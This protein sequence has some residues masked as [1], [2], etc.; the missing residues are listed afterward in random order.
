VRA[1][2]HTL[3]PIESHRALFYRDSSEYLEGIR[4][5]IDPALDR[6]EPVAIAVPEP[7]LRF[8]QAELGNRAAPVEFLDMSELGRNPGRIIPAVLGMLE[9]QARRPL[10]FV[11][12]PLWP[13]RSPEEI[14]E[15]TRHEALINLAWPDTDITV[16][17]PYDAGRL[18]DQV[19]L[20][21]ELTHPCVVRSGRLE[22]SSKYRD[23]AVPASCEQAL[24]DPPSGALAREFA[25]DDLAP[26]RAWVAELAD[27]S[28]LDAE[29]SAD[30]VIAINELTTNT[31]RHAGPHGMLRF[32]TASEE[33]IFQVE[34]T[35]HIADPLAG[36]R[37]QLT[38]NGG[39]GLW[40]ANQLCDLVEIRTNPAGTKIRTHL[41]HAS[42]R[43]HS[44]A[45]NGQLAA[46]AH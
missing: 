5:F 9:R 8:L 11:G 41:S 44:S 15:A 3:R 26:L 32:W 37:R 4:D 18:D 6:D 10:R 20:E 38:G 13:G 21:A 45:R 14:R 42:A 1:C 43:E 2:E 30:L 19:L 35:G 28:G 29:R 7:K 46:H 34:D 25:V 27:A 17:C 16:L 33:V 12:E 23:G 40:I 39:V 22:S 24:P 31:V 36:R